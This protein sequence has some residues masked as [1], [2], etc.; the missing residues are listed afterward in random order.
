[1]S[2]INELTPKQR[3]QLHEE[4]VKSHNSMVGE[5][6]FRQSIDHAILQYQYQLS[7][8]GGA[9]FNDCA[10]SHIKMQGAL[11]FINVLCNLGRQK[12]EVKRTDPLNL[13]HKA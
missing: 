2:E 7:L 8:H 10:A 6:N 13:D 4:S 3:F 9:G 5:Y 11:E 12:I 1:M